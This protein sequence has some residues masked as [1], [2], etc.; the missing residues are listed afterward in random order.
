MGFATVNGKI[1]TKCVDCP[2]FRNENGEKFC[3]ETGIDIFD[4]TELDIDCLQREIEDE[5]L[6]EIEEDDSDE[7]Y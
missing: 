6:L 7:D 5:E 3:I 1:Y 2:N 4:E